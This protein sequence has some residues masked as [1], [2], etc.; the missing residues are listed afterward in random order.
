MTKRFR[1]PSRKT[2]FKWNLGCGLRFKYDGMLMEIPEPKIPRIVHWRI[3]TYRGGCPGAIHY[4]A[5]LHVY[6]EYPTVLEIVG[7]QDWHKVGESFSCNM[8]PK[9]S[10]YMNGWEV[11]IGYVAKQDVKSWSMFDGKDMVVTRKGQISIAFS[12]VQEV[13]STMLSE[14]KRLFPGKEWKLDDKYG[15]LEDW[16]ENDYY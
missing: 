12:S 2:P 1:S 11:E 14:F 7:K 16:N 10:P 9:L 5:R 6:G 4:Y 15:K 8:F 13:K 3:T